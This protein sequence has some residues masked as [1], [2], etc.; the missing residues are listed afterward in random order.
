MP[1]ST[2][3]E[4]LPSGGRPRAVA[5]ES[6][7]RIGQRP[8]SGRRCSGLRSQAGA[9]GPAAWA[10]LAAQPD[11]SGDMASTPGTATW[12]YRLRFGRNR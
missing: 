3:V 6:I 1:Q 11:G 5:A 9:Q 2:G 7:F 8:Y 10:M 4:G 12:L